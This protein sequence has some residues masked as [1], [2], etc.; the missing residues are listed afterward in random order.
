MISADGTVINNNIPRPES[1]RVPLKLVSS[2]PS[3]EVR[4]H[5]FF[6]SNLFLPSAPASAEPPAFEVLATALPLLGATVPT[7]GISTS[8]ML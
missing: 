5:T 2:V 3:H 1:H 8:A 7:S 6:T 4:S